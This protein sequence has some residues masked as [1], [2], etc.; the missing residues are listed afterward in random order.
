MFSIGNNFTRPNFYKL[1]VYLMSFNI[2][3][4][5]D[6]VV[7]VAVVTIMVVVTVVVG[8]LCFMLRCHFIISLLYP[9]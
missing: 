5:A 1:V 2:A 3:V 8:C 7:I 6:A 9:C 4:V